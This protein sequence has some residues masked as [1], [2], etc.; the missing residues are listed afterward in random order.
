M[1]TLILTDEEVK[2]LIKLFKDI[3]EHDCMLDENFKNILE[4][5]LTNNS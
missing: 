4:K 2:D 1:K 5:L 3:E